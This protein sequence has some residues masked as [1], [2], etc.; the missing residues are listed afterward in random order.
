MSCSD[1]SAWVK[2][3][4][5]QYFKTN[6]LLRLELCQTCEAKSPCLVVKYWKIMKG[7]QK[8]N[9]FSLHQEN[10]KEASRKVYFLEATSWTGKFSVWVH[11]ALFLWK[12][13]WADVQCWYFCL[14]AIVPLI[15]IILSK[16]LPKF[17]VPAFLQRCWHSLQTSASVII[18]P[19]SSLQHQENNFPLYFFSHGFSRLY[20]FLC[21][22]SWG[23]MH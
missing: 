12:T 2:P 4:L 8:R 9:T 20:V 3:F 18:F 10:L 15:G 16:A 1:R 11:N 5:K 19:L 14:I 22:W 17:Y 23:Y 13:V 6:S 7:K 21:L